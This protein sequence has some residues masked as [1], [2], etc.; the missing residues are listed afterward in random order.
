MASPY[1]AAYVFRTGNVNKDFRMRRNVDG[2]FLIADADVEIDQDSK[3]I[4]HGKSYKGA[5]GLFELL[6]RKKLNRSFV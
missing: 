1:V 4:V 2:T 5:R 6:T 3:V